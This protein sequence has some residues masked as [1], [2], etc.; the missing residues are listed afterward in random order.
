MSNIV[1]TAKLEP[2]G[3]GKWTKLS[4]EELAT[5]CVYAKTFL[6]MH[7]HLNET[8]P[9]VLSSILPEAKSAMW[10]TVKALAD[11]PMEYPADISATSMS[12]QGIQRRSEYNLRW[13]NDLCDCC[14][15]L[16]PMQVL[17][18]IRGLTFSMEKETISTADVT[19]FLSKINHLKQQ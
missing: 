7:P 13:L 11:V 12:K 16:T 14:C 18:K 4:K 2:F 1:F 6:V 3:A 10:K 19:G 15:P 17:E 5:W 9:V 8:L